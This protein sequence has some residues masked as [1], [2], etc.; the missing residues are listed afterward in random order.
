MKYCLKQVSVSFI[1]NT[2]VDLYIS[3]EL[4]PCSRNLNTDF[5]LG[6]CLFGAVKV[7]KNADPDKC[8]YSEN[9]FQLKF[10]SNWGKNIVIFGV[11]MSSSVH[12][13]NKKRIY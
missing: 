13:D 10:C 1:H 3:Y 5:T 6:N 12:V 11:D 2:V 7:I 9:V 8:V 4:D